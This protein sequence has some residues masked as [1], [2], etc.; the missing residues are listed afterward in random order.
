MFVLTPPRG[1]LAF[2]SDDASLLLSYRCFGWC[3]SPTRFFPFWCKKPIRS[4]SLCGCPCPA[5]PRCHPRPRHPPL[6]HHGHVFF[7]WFLAR[8]AVSPVSRATSMIS[9]TPLAFCLFLSPQGVTPPPY[10]DPPARRPRVP[11][12]SYLSPPKWYAAGRPTQGASP[13]DALSVAGAQSCGHWEPPIVPAGQQRPGSWQ[14]QRTLPLA[15][16]R[17]ATQGPGPPL[18]R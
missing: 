1:T 16:L 10:P 11:L 13:P 7:R 17:R 3:K 6:R 2:S 15:S 9:V 8:G 5:M 12:S 14:N 18:A 4:F